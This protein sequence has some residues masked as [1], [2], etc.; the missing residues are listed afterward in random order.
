MKEKVK[1]LLSNSLAI[2]LSLSLCVSIVPLFVRCSNVLSSYV[3]TEDKKESK[4]D[5]NGDKEESDDTN[6]DSNDDENAEDSI[7]KN[8]VIAG[9]VR[10]VETETHD[11]SLALV[12]LL[13][14]DYEENGIVSQS[15]S[16]FSITANVF[17]ESAT[18]KTLLWELSFVEPMSEMAQAWYNEFKSMGKTIEDYVVVSVSED[19]LS[20]TV[21]CLAPF[22]AQM[23]LKV[24]SQ[25]NPDVSSIVLVDYEIRVESASVFSQSFD[26]NS[27]LTY[28]MS[29]N[30]FNTKDT[31]PLQEDSE[32]DTRSYTLNLVTSVGTYSKPTSFKVKMSPVLG[33]YMRAEGLTL[34]SNFI[35]GLDVSTFEDGRLNT[36]YIGLYFLDTTVHE[37]TRNDGHWSGFSADVI[38]A[39]KRALN[40]LYADGELCSCTFVFTYGFS[41][42]APDFS[43]VVG[44]GSDG[45]VF[46]ILPTD[47][48]TNEDQV[49]F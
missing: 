6:G 22:G 9:Q 18:N 11:L 33:E 19:T 24:Y 37:N 40:A 3:E 27:N 20:A 15:E 25:A 32:S 42:L 2:V 7:I 17:P 39:Y 30:T 28:N 26:G 14:S 8:P 49:I 45:P 12:P 35:D 43:Y 34:K 38:T 1:K 47:I 23:Q 36:L 48:E 10:L 31:K 21:S 16:A 41:S 46:N 13:A 5:T 44:L 29:L 4:D